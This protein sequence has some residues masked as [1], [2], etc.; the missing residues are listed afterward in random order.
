LSLT[1]N[2]VVLSYASVGITLLADRVQAQQSPRTPGPTLTELRRI[3]YP[4]SYEI[5]QMYVDIKAGV[6]FPR[7]THPGVESALILDGE[8][9]LNGEGEE[10]TYRKGEGFKTPAGKVHWG[11]GGASDCRVFATFVVE[12]D[13]P[14]ALPA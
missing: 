14:L 10:R 1:T 5:V 11:R 4:N 6:E 7:H 3:K 8:I 13:K 2:I 9:V 12:K